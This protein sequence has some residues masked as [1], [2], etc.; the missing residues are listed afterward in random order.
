MGTTAAVPRQEMPLDGSPAPRVPV[1]LEREIEQ[2]RR[3]LTGYCY[4]MLGSIFDAE[5]AVQEAMVRAWR[6]V[7][8]FDGRSS[9]RTW[10]YRITT[11]VCVD[12]LNGAR[13]RAMP[14]DLSPAA[15]PP[16][17]SSLGEPAPEATWLGPAPDDRVLPETSDPAELA[18]ARESV[19]LAFLAALQHLPPRQRA[20]LIL[21]DVLRWRADEVA[22][23]LESSTASVNSALQR[24]RATLASR[25]L[26]RSGRPV[27][28]A[29]PGHRELLDRYVRAFEAYDIA[30]LVALLH[31]DATQSMPPFSLWLSGP[32]DIG[33]WHLG[34]GKDCRGSRLVR[35][36][37]NGSPAL[38]QYRPSGPG[39]RFE[40]W[41][42]HVLHVADGRVVSIT[43]FLG[44]DLFRAFGLPLVLGADGA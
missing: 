21:R 6:A 13:R 41:A 44:D 8:R 4:R 7:D 32:E 20:V 25:D 2:H 24:A 39:G 19:R 14:V 29:D 36:R 9:L 38:A 37:A 3:E 23:L 30:A 17:L 5:D 43:N 10:L 18:V 15:S 22:A 1:E 40:P 34:P 12:A 42:V 28:P 11:N 16:V 31:E 33:R 35:V 26:D 27:D